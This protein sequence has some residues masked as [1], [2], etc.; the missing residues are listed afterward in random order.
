M[1]N[2]DKLYTNIQNTIR[3]IILVFYLI[4]L[5]PNQ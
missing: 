1:Y 3:Y 2:N 5:R 4:I